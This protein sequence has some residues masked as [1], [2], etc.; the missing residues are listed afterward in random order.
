MKKSCCVI[1]AAGLS[2][3]MGDFKPLLPIQGKPAIVHLI[4]T[5]QK[6][7][8]DH[9]IVVTGHRADDLIKACAHLSSVSFVHNPDYASTDMLA[10]VKIGFRAV[11]EEYSRVLLTPAD[12]PLIPEAVI[13]ELL[14]MM[15]P[16]IY[17][18]YEDTTGHPVSIDT[19]Y[20]DDLCVFHGDGGLRA[21]LEAL[22][23][24]PSYLQTNDPRILMDMDTPADYRQILDMID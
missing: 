17:P 20:L 18:I 16:L 11:S 1:V 12:I 24:T 10:S 7:G 15:D 6:A 4:G 3:R 21:A 23:V 14:N 8:I 22:P 9:C 2:S 13:R 19:A 5:M